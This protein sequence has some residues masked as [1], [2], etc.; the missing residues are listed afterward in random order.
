MRMSDWSS[1]VC[2]S[3]L[4]G[5]VFQSFQLLPSLTALENVMLPLELRGDAD[6]EGPA[7]A[8][9]GK[10][11]LA[12]RLA[13]YPRQLSGSE[14]QRVALARAFVPE[15]SL[16]LADEPTGI[17]ATPPGRAATESLFAITPHRVTNG[18]ID[19]TRIHTTPPRSPPLQP[20]ARSRSANSSAC[21]WRVPSSPGQPCCWPTSPPATSTPTPAR[22]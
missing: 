16:L 1:D 10:V 11:G 20:R 14:Q 15:P 9:L 21:R 4:V 17:L 12:E 13:H 7:R 8:T 3:D 18:G 6:A 2:S 5:F 22:R 19:V